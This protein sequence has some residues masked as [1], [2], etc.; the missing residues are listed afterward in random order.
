[1]RLL[2]AVIIFI[3]W[4]LEAQDTHL[5]EIR[6][7]LTPMRT[8]QAGDLKA[9]GASPVFTTVKHRLRDWIESRLAVLT[10]NGVRWSP[11]PVVLQERL[12]E[13]LNAAGLV[14]GTG[15]KQACQEWSELG[16]LGPVGLEMKAGSLLVVTTRVGVQQCGYD[17]SAYAYRHDE[18]EWVR[19]WES[20]QND[21]VEGKYFPQDLLGVWISPANYYPRRDRS[22]HLI[23][24]LGREPWCASN[25]HDVYY[26]VWLTNAA[27]AAPK[28]FLDGREWAYVAGDIQGSAEWRDVLFEFSVSSVEGGFTRPSIHHYRLEGDD[29]KRVDPVALSPRMFAAFWLTE[30]H[31]SDAWTEAANRS[32]LAAW[33]ESNKRLY[34]EFDEPALHCN[35]PDLW[36]VTTYLDDERKKGAYFLVRW[37]PPYRFTMVSVGDRPSEDC[38]ERDPAADE[39]RSVFRSR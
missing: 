39:R 30:A 29:L 17:D 5:D 36:Q 10:W 37:R 6:R 21:Y 34:S 19:F 4:L 20:E 11:D 7:L 13:E 27:L 25:W 15:T 23:L 26:R 28:L 22:E 32:K 3:P 18:H 1:M 24:T 35:K 33:R 38:T 16:F 31:G 9:R 12:N 2:A 14:C 8:G